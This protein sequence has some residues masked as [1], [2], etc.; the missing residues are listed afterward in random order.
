MVLP[1]GLLSTCWVVGGNSSVPLPPRVPPPSLMGTWAVCLHP[2]PGCPLC[3]EASEL[4][5]EA[6]IPP[7]GTRGQQA[8]DLDLDWGWILGPILV[9]PEGI[10]TV[11]AEKREGTRPFLEGWDV[12]ILKHSW[13]PVCSGVQGLWQVVLLY[14]TCLSLLCVHKQLT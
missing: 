2:F 7:P 12:G 9:M 3:S 8:L 6:E 11:W 10:P 1:R 14:W 13:S 4:L 5:L